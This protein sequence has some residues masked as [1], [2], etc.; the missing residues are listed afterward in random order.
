[1]KFQITVLNL[2]G[3][4]LDA[5]AQVQ[6]SFS[7]KQSI[8]RR[9]HGPLHRHEPASGPQNNSEHPQLRFC[10]SHAAQAQ[11]ATHLHLEAA[12]SSCLTAARQASA[13]ATP[14]P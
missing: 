7:N 4:V 10:A 5:P 6:A 2:L 14:S 11:S 13:S 8:S 12:D 3:K 9:H 1:M